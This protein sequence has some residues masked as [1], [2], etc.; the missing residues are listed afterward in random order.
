MQFFLAPM[1]EIS[2]ASFRKICYL[3]GAD[4]C[5][6]EMMS[7]KAIL[8]GNKKTLQMAMVLPD[9]PKTF[10]QIFGSEPEDIAEA[11]RRIEAVCPPYGFDINMG[12]PMKKVIKGRNGAFL[13]TGP[14]KV[15]R[16]V[17]AAR[18]ATKRPLSAKIRKGYLRESA[19]EIA[20]II[21]G[22]GADLLVIHPRLK[23]EMFIPG[24]CDFDL[25]IRIAEERKIP[26]IHSGDI[27]RPQD[28]ARF[29][30]SRIAGIMIGRGA[31]G[32]PWIFKEMKGGSF[33]SPEQKKE[34]MTLHFNLIQ[35]Y[36]SLLDPTG[37]LNEIKRHAVW[38]SK[39]M[40]GAAEFR[41]SLYRARWAKEPLVREISRFLGLSLQ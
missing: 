19:S 11:I 37:M 3:G 36:S 41:N 1:A 31:C 34:M 6:T 26:V 10:V 33:L 22:E 12:C 17:R 9:E 5:Y 18:Q 23:S 28:L 38:Y 2:T 4:V 35:V 8:F 30:G 27:L 14:E 7:A 24:T 32:S 16:I 20:A 13:M 39:S 21:E 15:R 40:P 29:A 25:S